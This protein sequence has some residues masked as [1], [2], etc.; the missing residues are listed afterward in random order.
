MALAG[1]DEGVRLAERLRLVPGLTV[2]SEG[3]NVTVTAPRVGQL[4]PKIVEAAAFVSA[5]LRDIQIREQNLETVFL[6]Y[7]GRELASQGAE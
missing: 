2:E 5:A 3:V 1:R 7:T 4:I 6:A